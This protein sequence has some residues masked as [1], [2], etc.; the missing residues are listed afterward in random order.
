MLDGQ[1]ARYPD[2]AAMSMDDLAAYSRGNRR[3]DFAGKL[4]RD[5][6]GETCFNFGN[7][8][9]QKVRDN[10]GLADW[11]LTKDFPAETKF[12]VQAELDRIATERW[13]EQAQEMPW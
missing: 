11:M 10:L 9:G 3:V 5:A 1:L 7:A 12:R 13:T 4:V 8:R 6:D 2:L